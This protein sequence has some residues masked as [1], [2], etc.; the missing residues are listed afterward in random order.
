MKRV[1]AG[2]VVLAFITWGWGCAADNQGKNFLLRHAGV[3]LGQASAI[4]EK[5]TPGH[6]V[7]A[8]LQRTRNG[9]IYEVEIIDIENKSRN[10]NVDAETG[11]VIP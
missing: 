2:T 5:N 8:E 11:K 9:V 7:K 10:V 3:T 6:A 4:A 1:A